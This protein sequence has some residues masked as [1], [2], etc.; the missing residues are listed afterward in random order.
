MDTRKLPMSDGGV[1][2]AG[3]FGQPPERTGRRPSFWARRS[4]DFKKAKFFKVR[5]PKLLREHHRPQGIAA[6]VC[7]IRRIRCVANAEAV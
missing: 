1:L 5:H 4:L 6:L 3:N 7:K 2:S